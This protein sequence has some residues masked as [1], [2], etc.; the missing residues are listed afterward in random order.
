MR[1]PSRSRRHASDRSGEHRRSAA[2]S[3]LAELTE[4]PAINRSYFATVALLPGI[5]FTPTNQLGNDTIVASGQAS[6]NNNVSVDGGYNAD[7]ASGQLLA[8]R[9]AR[10]SR[11]S[12]N[13]T[14]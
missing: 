5:Q 6:Q 7:D 9:C 3:G 4:L 8:R 12:R 11:R 13:F 10:R 2:T 1:K 14:W